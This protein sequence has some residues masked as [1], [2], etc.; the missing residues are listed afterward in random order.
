MRVHDSRSVA[1]YFLTQPIPG[2]AD[3]KPMMVV[4][5]SVKGARLELSEA[6][7]PGSAVHLLVDSQQGLIEANATVLW[8]EI[9]ELRHDGG[10]DRYLAGIL[11]KQREPAIET[12]IAELTETQDAVLIEDFRSEDRYTMTSPLTG[13]FGDLAP[14]SIVDLSMHGARVELRSRIQAQAGGTLRFQVDEQTGPIDVFASV[15][16][17]RPADNEMGFAAGLRIDGHEEVIRKAVHRLCTRAEARIDT[18]SLRRKFDAMRK[19][20]P[21]REHARTA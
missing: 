14:V 8:C 12:L 21:Q 4:D 11:F 5:V 10:D 6:I 13:A 9:D 16:W 19:S 20:L 18:L 17:C 15:A 3:G 1:R 7:D 2:S